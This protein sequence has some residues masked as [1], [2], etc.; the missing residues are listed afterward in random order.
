MRRR[1]IAGLIMLVCGF[2]RLALAVNASDYRVD[3]CEW[4]KAVYDEKAGEMVGYRQQLKDAEQQLLQLRANKAKA[5]RTNQSEC[6]NE[7]GTCVAAWEA[8]IKTTQDQIDGIKQTMQ[9]LLDGDLKT[10]KGDIEQCKKDLPEIKRMKPFRE[11]ELQ[12]IIVDINDEKT[13]RDATVERLRLC[14]TMSLRFFSRN[15]MSYYQGPIPTT[16]PVG[17]TNSIYHK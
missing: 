13:T 12:Q 14:K 7:D 10:L 8:Q 17:Q 2:S 15:G 5:A 4:E 9:A 16:L 3:T 6:H 1:T 11:S